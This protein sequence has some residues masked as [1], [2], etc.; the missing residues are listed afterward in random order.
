K[1]LGTVEASGEI[2]TYAFLV[3]LGGN[4]YSVLYDKAKQMGG[5]EIMN[6]VF[7]I[8]DYNL[9]LFIYSN[10]KWKAHA[11]VVKYTNKAKAPAMPVPAPTPTPTP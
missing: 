7:E 11:T 10:I 8:E 3:S 2:K 9:L 5:D 6:Y 4:G 1:I